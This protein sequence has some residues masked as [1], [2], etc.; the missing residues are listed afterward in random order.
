M[1]FSSTVYRAQVYQAAAAA[2]T[3]VLLAHDVIEGQLGAPRRLVEGG[4]AG[5]AVGRA[6]RLLHDVLGQREQALLRLFDE[7]SLDVVA[8]Q[9]VVAVLPVTLLHLVVAVQTVQSGFG[10]VDPPGIQRDGARFLLG[11]KLPHGVSFCHLG[12]EKTQNGK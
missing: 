1:C 5:P 10:D 6:G 2:A 8:P 4:T 3:Y 7:V 11:H 9:E 12:A